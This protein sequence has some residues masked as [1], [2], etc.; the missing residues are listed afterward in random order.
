MLIII[1]YFPRLISGQKPVH[2]L[3]I[4]MTQLSIVLQSE[5]TNGNI[6]LLVVGESGTVIG[7]FSLNAV[8]TT[9]K[10]QMVSYSVKIKVKDALTL[11]IDVS[12]SAI[13]AAPFA[14][15]NSNILSTSQ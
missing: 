2:L 8:L 9:N 5:V 12:L 13:G 10:W 15:V 7:Q 14:T 4:G 11:S 3:T 1:G 6:C